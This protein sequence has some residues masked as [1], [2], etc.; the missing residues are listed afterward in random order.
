M[1]HVLLPAYN[2]AETIS[3]TIRD[4]DQATRTMGELTRVVLVD[5]GSSDGTAAI[6]EATARDVG[7]SVV[8]LRHR[9]NGGLGAAIRT[10]IYHVL[11]QA[12]PDDVLVAMDADNTHP[13]RMM[14]EMIARVRAGRDVVIA[15]RYQEGAKVAGVPGYRRVL[16][17]ASRLLFRVCFPIKGVRDYTC[18]YRA[19]AIEPLRRARIVYGDEL[20]TQ[21]GF[22]ATVDLLLRLRQVGIVADE[23]PL[24]LDYS[25]RVGQSKMHVWKTVRS[26]LAL[27][28]RRLV[29]RHTRYSARR[30]RRV[31]EKSGA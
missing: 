26:S 4:I 22:E 2:E 16:S 8:I 18:G 23:V 6:A 15:S 20:C 14:P 21:R 1:I 29:D 7:T 24:E 17:D 11:D 30:V 5:D 27:I 28:G 25:S 10:G 12:G 31:V 19:Y 9:K 13:A 3:P